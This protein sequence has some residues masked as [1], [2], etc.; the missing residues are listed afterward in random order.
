M[1]IHRPTRTLGT[2]GAAL[3]LLHAA[4][5]GE[6]NSGGALLARIASSTCSGYLA[7]VESSMR[8]EADLSVPAASPTVTF[9]MNIPGF[10][11]QILLTRQIVI[12]LPA[13][14]GFAGFDALGAGAEIGHWDF[15]FSNPNNGAFDPFGPLGYDYRIPN[16]A[17][18]ANSAY[19]D[20][21]LNG[22]YDAGVDS[23][24]THTTGAGGEHIF[25]LV[26][27]SG[28]TNNNGAGGNCSYF[29]TDTRFVLSAG[30]VQLPATPGS[31][32]V[33]IVATSIDPDTGDEDDQQGTAPTVYQRTI[34]V[35][36]P[37]PA[38]GALAAATIATLAALR[39]RC[40]RSRAG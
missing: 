40:V 8:F 26:L 31:Y 17:V 19:A 1:R 11:T 9:E 13:S 36:V 37:E 24:G 12:T 39:R 32:D 38:G 23:T 2:L 21:R 29:D 34:P 18:D 14:F 4:C 27:P 16:F 5:A 30:V 3:W 25:T 15:D 33:S 7:V 20:T 22:S 10:G 35:I 6:D 28:G